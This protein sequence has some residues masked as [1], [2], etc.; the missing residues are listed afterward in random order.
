MS[1][2]TQYGLSATVM[3]AGA[4]AGGAG[5][6]SDATVGDSGSDLTRGESYGKE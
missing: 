4:G 2:F 5:G 6:P 3:P 1:C